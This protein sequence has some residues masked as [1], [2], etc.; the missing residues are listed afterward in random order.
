MPFADFQPPR[1]AVAWAGGGASV[2]GLSLEDVS[3]L[4][5]THYVD[6]EQLIALYDDRAALP[7]I[8]GLTLD[9]TVLTLCR[10]APQFAATAVLL[11][12][13]EAGDERAEEAVR[14]LPLPVMVDALRKVS[15]LTFEEA[16]GLRPFLGTLSALLAQ[17]L[18]A[19]AT[20]RLRAL[21]A[22]PAA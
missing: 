2:R 7:S 19:G 18:P 22:E 21:T 16:G 9:D 5:R 1:E 12:A 6:L 14:R 17:V 15:R 3:R 4:V 13:D 20:E 11:A 8:G 10:D